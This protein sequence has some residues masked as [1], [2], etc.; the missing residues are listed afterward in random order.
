MQDMNLVPK[1]GLVVMSIRKR[2]FS[3]LN[4][5][6]GRTNNEGMVYQAIRRIDRFTRVHLAALPSWAIST[7]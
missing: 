3:F 4:V 1:V 5:H 6:W 7:A 2:D